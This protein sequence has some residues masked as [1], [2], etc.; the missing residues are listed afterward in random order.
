MGFYR[1]SSYVYWRCKYHTVW[2]PKY[3]FRILR[4]KLDKELYRTICI[5]RG[6][7]DCEVPD[8]SVQ[9]DHCIL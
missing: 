8:L 3:R 9:P 7:K 5:L 4:D 1:S 2:A 6:I